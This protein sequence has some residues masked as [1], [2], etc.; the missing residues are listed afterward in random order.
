[1]MTSQTGILEFVPNALT[2]RDYLVDDLYLNLN[3]NLNV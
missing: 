3:L 1:M 2:I